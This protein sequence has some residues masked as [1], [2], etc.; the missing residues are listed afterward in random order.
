MVH[1]FSFI[2]T[3]QKIRFLGAL[4]HGQLY[5]GEKE[6]I[7]SGPGVDKVSEWYNEGSIIG[8]YAP[9]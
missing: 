4:G 5:L 8:I 7:I 6:K 3:I 9:S 2:I 1:S